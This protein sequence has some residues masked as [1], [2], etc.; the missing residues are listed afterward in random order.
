M[1]RECLL[2][3]WAASLVLAATLL[4]PSAASALACLPRDAVFKQLEAATGETPAHAGLASNGALLEV[5]VARDGTWTAC[6]TFPDGLTCPFAS[7]E[8]WRPSTR[9]AHDDPAA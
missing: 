5:T 7:G 2:P 8:A 9:Q 3:F 1:H 6:F 4:P